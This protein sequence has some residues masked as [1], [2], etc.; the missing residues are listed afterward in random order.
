MDFDYDPAKDAI[1]RA[2]HGV[3]LAFGRWVFS[4][5]DHI[6]LASFRPIDGE[7]R[8]KAAGRVEGRLFTAVHVW[9]GDTIRLISVRRSNGSEQGN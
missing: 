2:K 9:R 5:R 1:N 7:D 3:A 8:Y 6:V 4:D